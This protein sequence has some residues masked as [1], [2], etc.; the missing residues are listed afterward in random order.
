MPLNEN[1]VE[2][3]FFDF[4]DHSEIT[5]I[6][7]LEPTSIWKRGDEYI[8]GD[9]PKGVKK[10]REN[11]YW[12]YRSTMI[13]NDWIGDQI[14]QFLERIITPRKDVI[15]SLTDKYPAEFS[16]VQFMYDGCNPGLYFDKRA[17]STLNDSGLELNIDLYVLNQEGDAK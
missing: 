8:F 16:I 11:N 3:K 13:S 2:L 15:R 9:R 6:L 5:K 1:Y 4:P 17:M 14:K 10:I 7:N 12:E